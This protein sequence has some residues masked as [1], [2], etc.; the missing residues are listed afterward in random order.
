MKSTGTSRSRISLQA[1]ADFRLCRHHLLREAPADAVTIC[2]DICGV[3]AQVMSAAYLQ[4]WTRNHALTRGEVENALWRSRTLIKTSL[5]RQTLHIIPADE[6]QLYISALKPCRVAQALR[7]MERCGIHREEG[8][9]LTPLIMD[10]LAAGPLGRAGIAAAL[11]PRVSKRVIRFMEVSWS[12]VRIPIAEGLICYGGAEGNDITFTRTDQWLEKRQH[13]Q[14]RSRPISTIDA[15]CALLRKYLHAYG[16]ATPGDFSHWA[17]LPMPQVKAL[18]ALMAPELAEVPVGDKAG[19][20]LRED[21]AELEKSSTKESRIRLL[22]LFDPFL[23]AHREKDH[24][25]GAEHYK[26]VYRNQGWISPVVLIDG[27]IAGVWSHKIQKKNLLV[28][29][30]PFEN[31]SKKAR[32]GIERQANALA[33]FF[34]GDLDL[35]F[36]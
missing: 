8:E 7:V 21:V 24:L 26:R 30:E 19:F 27:E 32:T 28:T 25:L 31:L 1:I 9:S 2:G 36:A 10:A 33:I 15:Q 22:P 29:I 3:Q 34:A 14:L 23:L 6:F 11:R 5:M 17:G 12:H 18:P 13:K 16:P 4:L 35:K 20:M